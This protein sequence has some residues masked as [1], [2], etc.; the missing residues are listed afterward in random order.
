[1]PKI[2]QKMTLEGSLLTLC[3]ICCQNPKRGGLGALKWE[4]P[5]EVE[6]RWVAFQVRDGLSI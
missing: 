1:M 2:P 3:E 4:R 6:P 5:P